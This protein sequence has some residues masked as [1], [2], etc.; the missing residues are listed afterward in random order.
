MA[1]QDILDAG[2]A[3]LGLKDQR[4][5]LHW[6]K[7]NIRAFGGDPDRITIFGES[8]GGGNVGYH[9]TAF[10]GRDDHLFRGLIAQSGA[11][12]SHGK[13]LT[14]PER[15]YNGIASAAGCKDASNKLACLRKVPFAKLNATITK[16]TPSFAPI[17]D[18]DFVQD[19]PSVL[20]E[21]GKFT[22]LPFLLGTTADEATLFANPM[23]ATD[24]EFRTVVKGTGVDDATADILTALYPDID[25]LGLPAHYRT[26]TDG[27][28][29]AQYKRAVAFLTDQMFLSWR[30]LRA[31][32]WSE[33]GVPV[34]TY[35]FES[36]RDWSK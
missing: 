30:R 33:Q 29:G 26:P 25:A 16:I 36:P 32:A 12:G 2:V 9:A 28:V 5:A 31:N 19:Y 20:L 24:A 10:G 4:L 3:N 6:I 13:N 27:S 8:A 11:D 35:L 34:Y 1:S 22:K 14:N 21:K 17:V 15:I 18:G 23:V 7:E